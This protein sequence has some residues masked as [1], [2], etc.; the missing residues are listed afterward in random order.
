MP[1][2]PDRLSDRLSAERLP[3][4]QAAL[5][6]YRRRAAV[7]D[8]ELALFEP[9]RRRAVARLG[10]RPGDTVLDLACGTGLSFALLRAAVGARGRIVGVEQSPEMIERARL[11][12]A[13][14]GWRNVQLV[15][16][17]VEEA[18]LEGRADAALFHFTH[19]VLR[20]PEAVANV[21]RHL[22][23]GARIVASGLQWTRRGWALPANLLVLAAA[24]RSVTSLAGLAR[25]WSTLA[26]S[27]ERLEAE[28]LLAG[29]VYLV[30][31]TLAPR[32]RA[33]HRPR[34]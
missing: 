34:R 21:L 12:V 7:Y 4:R 22:K 26:P 2:Q 8:L 28:S 33:A 1:R 13:E 11:R 14:Q 24:R 20:R 18:V 23:P 30:T 19:D 17:P 31:G 27:L 3:D 16:A 29:T 6:Q 32:R 15:Q 5:R 25:P 10:L 9:I